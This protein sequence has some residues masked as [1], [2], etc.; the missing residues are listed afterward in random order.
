[1]DTK[2]EEIWKSVGIINGIDFRELYEISTFGRIKSL[3][4]KILQ[5]NNSKI[6][7]ERLMA[8][9]LS[10]TEKYLKTTL[11]KDGKSLTIRIHRLMA[12]IFIPNPE[13]KAIENHIDGNKLNNRIDNLEWV[14]TQEN[15]LH[16]FSK[17]LNSKR[18]EIIV[19]NLNNE[20]LHCYPSIRECARELKIGDTFI[21][22]VLK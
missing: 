2:L 1:M 21:Y 16:A 19:Y 10:P 6:I 4:R 18:F 3:K 17:G 11:Y 14:S 12:Q 9:K 15:S 20:Y 13:N 5:G 7:S 8:A 22:K